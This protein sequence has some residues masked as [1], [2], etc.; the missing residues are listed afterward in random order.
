M[1]IHGVIST[2]FGHSNA[3]DGSRPLCRLIIAH[4]GCIRVKTPG[5]FFRAIA[6]FLLP[7][8]FLASHA[9]AQQTSGNLAGAVYDPTGATVPSATVIAH[10]VATGVDTT[11]TST[12]AGE[13]RFENLPIG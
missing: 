11:T 4:S 10:N 6:S 5:A 12:S 8:A 13:F 3:Q 9:L 1:H 2:K 7:L